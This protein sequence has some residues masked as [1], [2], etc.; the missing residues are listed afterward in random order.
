MRSVAV[1][2]VILILSLFSVLVSHLIAAL[3]IFDH[4]TLRH[5]RVGRLRSFELF[6][7]RLHL[8]GRVD[9]EVALCVARLDVLCIAF[10]LGLD[11]SDL[12]VGGFD[13]RSLDVRSLDDRGLD[14]RS[15]DVRSLDVC[16][17]DRRL[18]V[19]LDIRLDDAVLQVDQIG[20]LIR[21][22]VVAGGIAIHAAFHDQIVAGVFQVG[23]G[24]SG[25]ALSLSLRH[26]VTD[27][28]RLFLY[29][30]LGLAQVVA[31]RCN[32]FLLQ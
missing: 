31:G 22:G 21:L 16:S 20:V 4:F 25:W 1:L 13:V 9:I 28:H 14:I 18:G 10:H 15:L 27:L 3:F 24:L 30:L 5:R 6:L 29:F 2:T 8:A 17:V 26:F 11:V 19:H 32:G 12:D 23:V 7:L